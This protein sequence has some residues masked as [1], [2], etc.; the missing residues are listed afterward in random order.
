MIVFGGAVQVVGILLTSRVHALWQAY[1]TYGIGVGVGV[2]CGYVP[3]VAV[4]GGW[5]AKRRTT[6][7]GLAVSGIG[8]SSLFGPP[9]AAR[10]IRAHGWRSAYVV[11]A[12][13]TAVLLAVV[14]TFIRTPP[15]FTAAPKFTLSAAIRTRTFLFNYLAMMLVSITLFNV[16]VNLVP[17]AEEHGIE[18]VKA[19]TLI[20]VLGASSV[21]GRNALAAL[22]RRFGVMSVYGAS[23]LAMGATQLIWMAAG[24]RF[25]ALAVFAGLF[26]VAYGGLI[27]LGPILLAEL[28]GPEQLGGL[29]GINYSASGL[30]ALFGPTV[31]AWLVDRTGGY[32]W[33]T[34]LGFMLGVVAAAL[35]WQLSRR[36]AGSGHAAPP[37]STATG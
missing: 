27:A 11:F 25:S 9:I 3:M 13:A 16:F 24:S 35:V 17:Y 32:T 21:V 10:L 14:A 26:G 5:F 7:I 31:G 20:S 6:A 36:T 15:A 29:A 28:F 22:A 30:G 34:G 19:A 2:A 8:L 33:S 23:V 18:K 12:A 37:G 4:V 1:L